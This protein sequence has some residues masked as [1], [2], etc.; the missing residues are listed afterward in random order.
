MSGYAEHPRGS[1][2]P[3]KVKAFSIIQILRGPWLR[4][5][6]QISLLSALAGLLPAVHG[7]R[8]TEF[9]AVNSTGL[10]DEDGTAQPWVEIWNQSQVS[11]L[12]LTN[13]KLS[14]TPPS[15]G[16]A[17]V[18]T[19]PSIQIMPDERIIIWASGKN[20]SV[21]TAPLH[22]SFILP[23][24][25]GS[26]LSL[27]GPTSGVVSSFT[28][29]PAQTVDV[30]WGRDDADIAVT[31][32]LTGF[33]T[34]PTAGEK[35]STYTGS[36]VAGGV[37]F[38]ETSRAF[39]TT[40]ADAVISVSIMQAALDPLAE[41]RYN[42]GFANLTTP[43][44]LHTATPLANGRV[45]FAG[46]IGTSNLATSELFDPAGTS[47]LPAGNLAEARRLHTATRL[48]D[49]K[50]LVAGGF[51]AAALATA[52]LYN[53]D[54]NLWTTA[55]PLATARQYHTA[56]LLNNGKVLVVG[57]L[58]AAASNSCELYDPGTNTWTASGTLA[59]ARHLHT[60]NLLP[61]GNVIITGGLGAAVLNSTEIYDPATGLWTTVAD[62]ATA[63]QQHTAT[64]LAD[65]R[66]LA[67][68]GFGTAALSS[69]ELYDAALNTWS[70]AA[71]LAS[72]RRLH[73]ATL[74]PGGKVLV[75]GGTAS[76]TL[77]ASS[78]VAASQIYDPAL[79]LWA[80]AAT[81]AAGRNQH[82]ATLLNNDRVLVAGGSSFG[83]ALGTAEL[84]NP[85]TNAAWIISPRGVVDIPESNSLLY[86]GPL[87]ISTTQMIR[88]RVFK[89]G[90]LPGATTTQCFLKLETNARTY[91]S[92]MP[93]TV[94]STFGV[95]PPNDG[96][97]PAFLWVWQPTAPDNRARFTTPPVLTARTVVDKRGSSTLDNP[98][99][100]L[101]LET[102]QAYDEDEQDLP[103]LGMPAHSDWVFHA[104]FNF[105]RSLLHNPL[106]YAMSN[107]TGRYAVRTRMAEVF[108]EISGAGLNSP[109]GASGDYFGV[110]NVME[111]IRRGKNRVD[112]E[113][114]ETDHNDPIRKTGGYIFKVD[115]V[116]QGDS[117]FRIGSSDQMAYYY[118][119][120]RELLSPQ[121]DP[122]EKYL[123]AYLGEF[124]TRVQGPNW[125]DPV[126]GYA[127]HLD[128]PAAIDHHLLNV[129]TF[130]VDALRLSGYWTKNRS[131]KLY[132]GPIWDFDRALSSTD[133]RDQ[134]PN[135]WRST[136]GDMG[137][138]FFNYYWWNRLFLDP[139]FYQAYIDRWQELRAG[140]LSRA[141]LEALID[142]LNAAISAEAVTRDLARWGQS[143]RAWPRPFPVP[144]NN[145]IAAGQP[146]EVQRLKDYLRQ[147]A[148]FM[149][150]Q[151]VPRVTASVPAGF[152]TSGTQVTLTGPVGV[153]IYYTLDGSDPRPSGGGQPAAGTLA[154]SSPI[155]INN[156]TRLRAR[157]YRAN[158]TA[159]T[160]ANKPPLV[161]KWGGPVDSS[162]TTAEIM[163]SEINYHPLNPTAAE[164]AIN[165]AWTDND[166]EFLEI[167]NLGTTAIDLT[168]ANFT[169]GVT[170]GFTGAA[171]RSI[172]AGESV[173]VASNP[174]A[175]AARYGAGIPVSGPWVGS[176]SNGGENLTLLTAGGATL[177]SVDYLDTW[178]GETDGFGY[179]LVAW[180][181]YPGDFSAPAA[182][183]ASAMVG[184]SPAAWDQASLP[185]AA[186]P[187]VTVGL[188]M[189]TTLRGA[190]PGVMPPAIPVSTWSQISGPGVITF[191]DTAQPTTPV[192]A[193]LP[194]TYTIRLTLNYNSVTTTDEATLRFVDTPAAWLARNAGIGTM[195]DDFDG[196][197]RS[198][199]LEF[200]LFTD[201][202]A[203]TGS[204]PPVF[205]VS[206]NK[207][208]L[209]WQRHHPASGLTYQVEISDAAGT[210][211]LP[212]PS[213]LTE[214]VLFDDGITQTVRTTDTV[215]IGNPARRFLR[216]KVTA[217]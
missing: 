4:K 211:R 128:V 161:S 95:I 189:A 179:S 18:W 172:A 1:I 2:Q 217:P 170:F 66:L 150:T 206:A 205:S 44:Q 214:T 22:T 79:N 215:T 103:L 98:K 94:I 5:F 180:Q 53:S 123:L 106:A 155:P 207:L 8:L 101:N 216:I 105:D 156:N 135:T 173:I 16:T 107:A 141:N 209:N 132:P 120:E 184:G 111:K 166:F 212:N 83:S 137:T 86:T 37:V 59:V 125:K 114:L 36:G 198:N 92:A 55:A 15:P 133:G 186:G 208:T 96:D 178:F 39:N 182:W 10:K 152:V 194:G 175:F 174:I 188:G 126:L 49:G 78:S 203:S 48:P 146:A 27:L 131:A 118:P 31:P 70:P 47:W 162:Y 38:S 109:G 154:Y 164:L 145:T 62:M 33:Y 181:Y 60:A 97:Q 87:T 69:A 108:M 139:D 54:T 192:S 113:K 201:P 115:R 63:R 204:A 102:R 7:Q 20:R 140:P 193:S 26:T 167:R 41:I 52:E 93:I 196:D 25:A 81:L 17:T 74:I 91:S 122:Q 72:A 147:R 45:L 129:W 73:S 190:L 124:N 46:G 148:N 71:S 171:A 77:P 64:V 90:L 153:P 136:S 104:P 50:V 116:D 134:D 11:V 89:P 24:A 56:T 138:D 149:D 142:A 42:T 197:G 57:G 191:G 121:R 99:F 185:V 88:A 68:A 158:F 34:Q 58:G 127:T 199:F 76:L 200:A 3:L 157:A 110:Y 165:P 32:L 13:Y 21:V 112:I 29:Y 100:S 43:R 61:N 176:L 119:K 6:C 187:D 151:W 35:N 210:F 130:N 169:R 159:Q 23:S 51:G 9:L 117:G 82:T 195:T 183:R 177:F 75:T 28:S 84:Y 160:G 213:E 85:V 30:S 40:A 12:T 14:S 80:S 144:E 202:A 67:V 163:L 168:G 143:K 65:G 19:I